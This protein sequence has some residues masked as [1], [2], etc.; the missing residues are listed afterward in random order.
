MRQSLIIA[1]EEEKVRQEENK[2]RNWI[3][4]GQ[5]LI[6]DVIKGTGDDLKIISH[7]IISTLIK[8]LNANQGGLFI[9]NDD[10]PKD[11]HIEFP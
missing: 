1:R 7:K 8:Y 11:N 3:A 2:V 6:S 10:N 9:L 5:G 4:E